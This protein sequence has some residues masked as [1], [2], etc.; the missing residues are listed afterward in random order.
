MF[1]SADEVINFNNKYDADFFKE[2]CLYFSIIELENKDDIVKLSDI[3]HSLRYTRPII[4]YTRSTTNDSN[5]GK[6]FC[7]MVLEFSLDEYEK[8]FDS[9]A[10]FTVD[11]AKITYKY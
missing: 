10:G 9:I 5:N 7:L 1:F 3:Q 6:A 2:N 11:K 4:E 8:K